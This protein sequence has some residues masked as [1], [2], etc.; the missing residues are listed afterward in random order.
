MSS[1]S[2][3]DDNDDVSSM[4]SCMTN[5]TISC[6]G[7]ELTLEQ[8][9]DKVFVGLQHSLNHSQSEL[10]CMA[11]DLDRDGDFKLSYGHHEQICDYVDELAELLFE[12][13]RVSLQVLGK[14]PDKETQI[15]YKEQ[16][17]ARKLKLKA[18]KD[19]DKLEKQ[20]QINKL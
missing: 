12:L 4:G 11:V 17:Q 7:E 16:V 18:K 19:F 3:N 6:M 15:W 9:I 1:E 10:R 13:K 20:N 14:A 2:K 5:M 8:G